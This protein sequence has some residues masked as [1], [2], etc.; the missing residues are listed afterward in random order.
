MEISGG[1]VCSVILLNPYE[2]GYR[3]TESHKIWYYPSKAKIGDSDAFFISDFNLFYQNQ[4]SVTLRSFSNN[5][6]WHGDWT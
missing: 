5:E 3:I 1:C 2:I 4:M 6:T